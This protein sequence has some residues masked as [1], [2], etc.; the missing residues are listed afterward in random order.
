MIT[1]KDKEAE[2]YTV[3]EGDSMWAIA[4]N[5]GI[6]FT[7]FVDLNPDVDPDKIWPGDQLLY[8]PA[9]PKLDV[10]V[11]LESTVVE[12]IP[13]TT[14]YITD[15]SMYN[16]QYEVVTA[17]VNGESQVTYNI[18]MVNGYAS[19]SEVVSQVTLS[20][21]TGRVVKVG[22]K[23]TLTISSSQNYGVVKG[24]LSSGYGWRTDPISGLRA[25]HNGIDIAA[26]CGTSVYAYASGTVTETGWNSTRGN[27]IIIDHGGGLTTRYLHLSAIL[28][29]EGDSVMTG[30]EIG[31]VGKT[32]YATGC[33]LHFGVFQDDE[34][35]N[36]FDYL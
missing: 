14:S 21:P 2:Y 30:E 28:V 11:K 31:E 18:T 29:S 25:Y 26:S 6:S 19:S 27:Y 7:D 8:S 3:A 12:D 23:K 17:G 4:E 20:V 33:H 34:D 22:T 16:S 15:S 5:L 35:Q 36:P 13:Y 1:A 10:Q 32:G 9:D 24:T